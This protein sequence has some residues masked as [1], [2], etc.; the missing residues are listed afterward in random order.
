MDSERASLRGAHLLLH[1]LSV[2]AVENSPEDQQCA[3]VRPCRE[4]MP[5]DDRRNDHGDHLDSSVRSE[6]C[7]F[8]ETRQPAGPSVVDSRANLARSHND[9]E[10]NWSELLDC[11]EDEQLSRRAEGEG[12]QRPQEPRCAS[13]RRTS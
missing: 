13:S 1:L 6:E 5:E 8:R 11:V 4:R 3:D 2:D 9:G 7:C 12:E 10:D